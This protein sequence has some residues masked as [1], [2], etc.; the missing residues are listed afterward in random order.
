MDDAARLLAIEEISMLKARY[1]LGVDTQDWDLLR[2]EVFI[3][4]IAFT[5]PEFRE[6]PYCGQ[7][8]VLAMFDLG[9]IGMASVHHGHMPMIEVTSDT[10]AK[11]VWAMEDRIYFADGRAG[12]DGELQLH[13]FG[14]Y[15]ETYIKTERGWRIETTKLTRLRKTTRQIA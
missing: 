15:H 10:T 4:E 7:E 3:P 13:G 1:F 6:E 8:E 12:I 14:H 9:L 11:G 5:L 2:R